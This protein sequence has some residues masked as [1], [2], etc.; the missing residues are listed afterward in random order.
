M[1]KMLRGF[2][3]IHGVNPLASAA[4]SF[5][6]R[7]LGI[8]FVTT[9]HEVFLSDLRVLMNSPIS[10]WTMGDLKVHAMSYPLDEFLVRRCIKS[11]EHIVVCGKTAFHDMMRVYHNLDGEKVS[12]IYNGVNFDALSPLLENS[13]EEEFFVAY[14]GRLVWRKGLVSLIKA[15]AILR[16]DFPDLQLRVCGRGP[17]ERII[18]VLM[19]KLSLTDKVHL[20]GHVPR[21]DL[22]MELQ[23]CSF[24]VL[25]SLYEVGP[26]ISGLEVMAC[27]KALVA[28]DLP[29][30]REFITH[31]KTGVLAK[32]GDAEDLALKMR[33]ILSDTKL[34]KSIAENAS[35][36]V[37]SNHNWDNLVDKYLEIYERC[38]RFGKR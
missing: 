2:D 4:C 31:M 32:P 19:K 22:V 24:A 28:S 30:N 6:K 1:L 35:R 15:M 14:H 29:F 5:I 27:K 9:I 16:D 36:Y 34:R 20:L 18:T 21:K 38:E 23:T 13:T 25:P 3:I 17:L 37:K 26:F 10:D 7:R 11:A 12:V 33:S 8:P